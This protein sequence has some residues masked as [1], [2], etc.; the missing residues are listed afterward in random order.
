MTLTQFK[1]YMEH[2]VGCVNFEYNGYS[3]GVDPIG[4]GQYDMWCGEDTATVTSVD[5]VLTTEIFNGKSLTDI[6]ND[7]SELD[8]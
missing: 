4:R 2:L 3:C 8:Y 1:A 7:I 6:W 5:D